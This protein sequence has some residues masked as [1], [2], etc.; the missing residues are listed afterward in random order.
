MYKK[1]YR[2]AIQCKKCGDVIES[3]STHKFVTCSCGAV[4]VDG[5][6]EYFRRCGN[7]EDIIELAVYDPM[8]D[9][10]L[11]KLIQNEFLAEAERI[12]QEVA[13]ANLPPMP[14]EVKERIW[15]N[16]CNLQNK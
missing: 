15:N 8:T 7:A 9:E 10:A 5:G 12:D 2:N 4:S 11:E 16:I 1:I 13:A 3:T 6:H 14:A